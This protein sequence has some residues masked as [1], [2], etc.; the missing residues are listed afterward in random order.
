MLVYYMSYVLKKFYFWAN[1]F[2]F[3]FNKESIKKNTLFLYFES[4]SVIRIFIFKS[5]TSTRRFTLVWPFSHLKKFENKIAH[6]LQTFY[7]ANPND[8]S[9]FLNN[10]FYIKFFRFLSVSIIAN[11]TKL[12]LKK[13]I[14]N[15]QKKITL[16]REI[17]SI[18][19]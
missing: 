15:Q 4:W 18:L 5:I 16:K 1:N 12:K 10:I 14:L 17:L 9:L 2:E 6:W 11:L 7:F 8:K 19:K 13:I 3:I